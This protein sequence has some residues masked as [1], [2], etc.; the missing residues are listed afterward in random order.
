MRCIKDLD[1]FLRY[2]AP[3]YNLWELAMDAS[4]IIEMFSLFQ[5]AFGLP[6]ILIKYTSSPSQFVNKWENVFHMEGRDSLEYPLKFSLHK[7]RA[8]WFKKRFNN[9]RPFLKI[10]TWRFLLTLFNFD[11]D[12]ICVSQRNTFLWKIKLTFIVVLMICKL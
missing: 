2:Y 4:L 9:T 5:T 8:S 7:N 1:M 12:V 11:C 3:P 10:K 6:F